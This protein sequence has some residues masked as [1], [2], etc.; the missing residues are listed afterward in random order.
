MTPV[1]LWPT[2]RLAPWW[3]LLAATGA[4]VTVGRLVALS[5]GSP[6]TPGA[7]LVTGALAATVAAT[8]DDR[9]HA[10]LAAV[11]TRPSRRLLHRLAVVVPAAALGWSIAARST[12]PAPGLAAWAALAAA[13]VAVG[14]C[15]GH[16]RP[17]LAAAAGGAAAVGWP[18]LPLV[19]LSSLGPLADGWV[20]H[21]VVVLGLALAVT[22]ATTSR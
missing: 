22:A 9:C 6:A 7:V 15:T 18:V 12:A 14:A 5:G 3:S 20:E 16:R 2:I 8:L 1:W 21:P 4:G 17:E 10:L 13:G 11:P 19:G